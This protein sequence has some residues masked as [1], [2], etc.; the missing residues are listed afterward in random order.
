[1]D[2]TKDQLD[3]IDRLVDGFRTAQIVMTANRLG[4]FA[5]LDRGS[6][7]AS[8][9]ADSLQVSMRGITILCDALVS[10]ELLEKESGRYRN[11]ETTIQYLLPSSPFGKSALLLHSAR[12]YNRWGTLYETVKQGKPLEDDPNRPEL[13]R[14]DADFALAMADSARIPARETASELDLTEVRRLLDLG[15]GPGTFA[16]EL[17]RVNPD[18]SVVIMDSEKTLQVAARNVKA[19]GLS[20]R[21]NLKIG[22]AFLDDPGRNFDFVLLSNVVHSYSDEKNR[23]LIGRCALA[24]RPGGRI[25]VKDFILSPDRTSPVGAALFAVNMLVNTEEGNC[26]TLEEMRDWFETGGLRYEEARPVSRFSMLVLG[27]KKPEL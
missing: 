25:C 26:Y 7:K 4:V 3:P 18:L 15:G 10:L 20:D 1:M 5:L 27:R 2:Q 8:E 17:A 9:I 23:E 24:L 14:N 13:A 22:D 19:A 11:S 16:I 6:L 21:I 12:L